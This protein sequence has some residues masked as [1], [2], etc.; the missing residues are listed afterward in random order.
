MWKWSS[1]N[2]NAA[3]KLPDTALDI[4]HNRVA[5][6][7]HSVVGTATSLETTVSNVQQIGLLPEYGGSHAVAALT[8]SSR[9]AHGQGLAY[10]IQ[11]EFGEGQF[12]A[13]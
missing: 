6:C 10:G 7:T 11:N 12:T 9:L 3:T 13:Q 4:A 2:E 5:G 1:Q 8:V